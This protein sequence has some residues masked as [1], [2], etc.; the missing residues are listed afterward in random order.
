MTVIVSDIEGTLT[1]GSSWKAL[2]K[3]YK[4]NYEPWTYNKFFFRWVPRYLLVHL[5]LRSRRAAMFDWMEDEVRL[6]RDFSPGDF[7]QMA[8]WV[9]EIEMW[10]KRRQ[11]L[12]SELRAHH[13]KGAEVFVVSSAYQPL[14]TAFAKRLD[15]IPIGTPLLF[16]EER[17]VGIQQPV[18]AYEHKAARIRTSV[19]DAKILASYGD[20]TSDL[21]MMEMSQDPVAVYPDADLHKIALTK[22]WRIIMD[23]DV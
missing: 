7:N 2:R 13:Q 4:T 6:F 22:G 12:I 11:T 20:T 5:G 19:G 14:V 8:E 1:T 17:L 3:Y 18:N 9:V 23:A 15:A 21:P 10:P 16:K